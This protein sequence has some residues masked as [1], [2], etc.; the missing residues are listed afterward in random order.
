M[1]F[2]GITR[3]RLLPAEHCLAPSL[4]E[5]RWNRIVDAY[6]RLERIA[7]SPVHRLNRAIAMAQWRGPAAGLD[8]LRGYEPPTWLADSY[9][10]SAV[11]ADLHGRCGH[12]ERARHHRT[13]ALKLAP[14]AAVQ[15]L[16]ERRLAASS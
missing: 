3:K 16:L 14:S 8:V 5:T 1:C 6:E 4:A 7:P 13:M 2:P 10:W 12:V 15:T 9:M 11:L